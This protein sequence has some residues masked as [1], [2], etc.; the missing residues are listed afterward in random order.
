MT[1]G[2]IAIVKENLEAIKAQFLKSNERKTIVYQELSKDNLSLEKVKEMKTANEVIPADSGYDSYDEWIEQLE[3]EI[4]TSKSSLGKIE[5]QE[6]LVIAIDHF[7]DT[8]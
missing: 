8:M 3:K 5:E 4:T 6:F 2:Q 7:I 1:I